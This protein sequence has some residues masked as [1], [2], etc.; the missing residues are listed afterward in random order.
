MET[1]NE[2]ITK[3]IFFSSGI[4]L[5]DLVAV[6]IQTKDYTDKS[7]GLL[8]VTKYRKL[9]QHLSRLRQYQVSN[10]CSI[11]TY[12]CLLVF[13]LILGDCPFIFS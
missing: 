3:I 2:N 8:S 12:T 1:N 9:W 5:K 13:I 6:D 10:K 11:P 7:K 4:L